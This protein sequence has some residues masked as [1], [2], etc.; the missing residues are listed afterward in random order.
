MPIKRSAAKALRQ[1]KKRELRNKKIKAGVNWLRHQF[2]KAISSKNKKKA[3]DFYIRMQKAIDSA[4]QKGVIKKNT[5]A[6]IKSRL[7]DKLNFLK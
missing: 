5:A 4:V 6:R 7:S 1:S 3:A 2:L